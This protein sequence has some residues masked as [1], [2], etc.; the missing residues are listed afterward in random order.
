MHASVRA[1]TKYHRDRQTIGASHPNEPKPLLLD[2][3]PLAAKTIPSSDELFHTSSA[4]LGAFLNRNYRH[5]R[6]IV[7]QLFR[8]DS[9]DSMVSAS[10]KPTAPHH[11]RPIPYGVHTLEHVPPTPSPPATI[12]PLDTHDGY[13]VLAHSTQCLVRP[14]K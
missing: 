10:A 14:Y 12:E 9:F 13:R 3:E 2:V 11:S 4:S 7:P 6:S 1:K 8:G 5:N